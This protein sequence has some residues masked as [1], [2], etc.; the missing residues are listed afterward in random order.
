[1]IGNEF[2]SLC[3]L[4]PMTIFKLFNYTKVMAKS[5]ITLKR[6]S[7]YE[8]NRDHWE[9]KKRRKIKRPL[10]HGRRKASGQRNLQNMI[11]DRLS[12]LGNYILNYLRRSLCV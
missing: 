7:H 8:Q 11:S 5:I 2:F 6:S 1:M 4:N 3:W 10:K 12:G 9:F